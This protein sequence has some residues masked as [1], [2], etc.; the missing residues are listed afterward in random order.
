MRQILFVDD[1]PN[2]LQGLE[3]ILFPFRR[4]WEMM[5]VSSG[6]KAL[7]A[8]NSQHFDVVV[9]D[10]RMPGMDGAALL[11]EIKKRHPDTL[12]FVLSGQ[13]DN[14]TLY[15]S[16]GEAHQFLSKP[17]K[18]QVLK[19][20]I[21]KAFALRELLSSAT[22]KSLVGQLGTLPPV[23]RLYRE[24]CDKL[25]SPDASIADVGRIIE[26]DPAMTAKVLQLVNSAFFGLRR[27]VSTATQAVT[28]LGL[29]TVKSVLLMTGLFAPMEEK[30]VAHGFSIEMIWKHSVLVGARAQAIAKSIGVSKDI[31]SDA[32]T[33]GLLHDT[34]ELLLAANSPEDYERTH[35][36]AAHNAV[37]ISDAEK[38]LL[39]CNHGEIG[40][41][42]LGI[43]GLPDRVV[44]AVAYHHHPSESAG[45][46]LSPLTVVH[47]AD[48]L[49]QDRV[50]GVGVPVVVDAVYIE[51]LGL[52]EQYAEWAKAWAEESAQSTE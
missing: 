23:P 14:E 29:D 21:D 25:Q 15:R 18:P 1:E 46:S 36:Y 44:E 32:Y 11:A 28:L 4:E 48:V 20:C 33:A 19:E 47:A 27:Q 38:K 43:W 35:D 39:G 52:S 42:L 7:D 9:S 50:E 6:A 30:R 24:L 5:F 13:S 16:V 17:C 10:M 37:L 41:Y 26:T 2:I 34:G 51:R 22:M 3:R 31:A 8:L 40:A 45:T 49:V 12:R